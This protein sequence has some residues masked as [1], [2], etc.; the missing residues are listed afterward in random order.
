VT[1]EQ[2]GLIG[3]ETELGSI[4]RFL[5]A[6]PDGPSALI[7]RGEPG[8]GKSTLWEAGVAGARSES[9]LVMSSRPALAET[10]L[11][12]LALGDLFAEVPEHL[13]DELPVPQ[14]KALEVALL[15]TEGEGPPLQQRAVS[16]A[17]LNTLLIL[18][19]STP[20]LI[21]IDDAQ[22]LDPPSSR[23]LRFALRRMLPASIGIMAAIRSGDGEQDPLG[24][25]TALPAERLHEVPLGPLDLQALEHVLQTRLQATLS[26]P[27]LR[28][29]EETSGGNPFFALELARALL[30]PDASTIPG[31]HLPA[32]RTL[33]DL[34]DTRLLGLSEQAREALL[35]AAA[36]SRPTVDLVCTAAAD[37]GAALEGLDQASEAGL[38][39]LEAGHVVFAH[40]LYA[41]VVYSQASP[42]ELR[43]LHEHLASL[44][45]DPDERVRL[46]GLAA[47]DPDEGV[48]AAMDEAARRAASRGAQDAAATFMEQAIRLTPPQLTADVISR[49]LT[50]ADHHVAAGDTSRARTLLEAVL[51]DSDA[52]TVRARALH[53][54]TRVRVL[55]GGFGAA[56]PLLQQALEEVGADLSLRAAI[57]RDMV[58]TLTQLGELREALPHAREG[59]R[60]AEATGKPVLLAEALDHLCMAELVAGV[61]PDQQLLDRAIAVEQEVGP[62][63]PLEHPGMGTGCLPLAVTLKWMDRFDEAR[64][65][66]RALH[67]DHLEHGDEGALAPVLFGLG[68]L[69]CWAGDWD[70]A[71][72]LA[73]E[74][75][76][77][78]SRAGQP[79]AGKI[80]LTLESMVDACRGDADAARSK[81]EASLALSEKVA[82]PRS[83]I[84]D[85]KTLG[86]LE[87][88]LGRADVAAGYLDRGLELERRAGYDPGVMRLLPDA[89]EAMLSIG[90]LEEAAPLVD[91][92]EAHG[93]R[94]D[95]PWAL[96]TGARC[97]GLL[98][99][100]RGDL[101][102]AREALERALTEHE[103]LPQPLE[104]ARTHVALGI[105]LRRSK[106]K[107]AARESLERALAIFDGLGAARWAERAHT[108]LGR[109]GGRA[110]SPLDLTPTEARIAELVAEGQTNR[111]V[112]AAVFLSEKTVETNLTR[113]FRKMGVSSRRELARRIR[114]G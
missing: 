18:A 41:S 24:V 19:R 78:A 64:E 20:T 81:A 39:R 95:R 52:G 36:L 15:R 108:E 84:R 40:P 37:P 93:R 89:V 76:A 49:E 109:I 7:I 88:S 28:R 97:R 27:T 32:T 29:L 83:V 33:S 11:P 54:L 46:L 30:D 106:Q 35:V 104:L 98:E 6:V 55:E 2:A 17:V 96:A 4:A 1:T 91:G 66:L 114:S 74:C 9:Y 80:A 77:L 57:E 50:A 14:R 79:I 42:T 107:R 75:H 101:D 94:L 13:L 12:Y 34:L 111:E 92:L 21:A 105:V 68:E 72:R 8:I 5:G 62:A 56:V 71:G 65:L 48:A 45:D 102:E 58:F 16:A 43:R 103:R 25:G 113:I 47:R 31:G 87:L 3:R 82:D 60:A 86:F 85:L 90:R 23:V 51:A 69:E 73:D 112:A 70:A 38:L 67:R 10:D 110:P 63:P 26:G 59:L 22:W 100:A 44:V 99:A 61:G 53:R